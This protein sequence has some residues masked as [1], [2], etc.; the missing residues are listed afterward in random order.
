MPACIMVGVCG[1]TGSGKTTFCKKVTSN[2]G[3]S[4]IMIS[5]DMYYKDLSHLSPEQRD[6]KN[7][8][9]PDALD[10]DLFFQH[11]SVL[12]QGDPVYIPQYDF[13]SHTRTSRV[14]RVEPRDMAMVEGV[15]LFTDDHIRKLLDYKIYIE[16]DLDIRFI[17]RLKRDVKDRDR[18]VD[19]VI[20]QYIS[21]V[22]PLHIEYV[23]PSRNHA[24]VVISGENNQAEVDKIV[25]MIREQR[26]LDRI[27]SG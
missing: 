14:K 21:T 26:N 15:M 18:S 1:G 6:R 2:I 13:K 22:K 11:L 3:P 17:R 4:A 25:T 20:E 5:Q 27:N 23:E 10:N 12:K 16:L 24:D 8:D 7:F 19:S 9:H